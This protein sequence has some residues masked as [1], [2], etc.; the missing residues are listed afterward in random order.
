LKLFTVSAGRLFLNP[1]TDLSASSGYIH[2]VDIIVILY[3]YIP[4]YDSLSGYDSIY[5]YIELETYLDSVFG[6]RLHVPGK[7]ITTS[8][9]PHWNDGEYR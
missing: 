7:I 9:R 3:G 4:S 1:A 8:L 2:I 6:P 5:I